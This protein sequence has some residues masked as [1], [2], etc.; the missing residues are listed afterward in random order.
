MFPVY[1]S[2]QVK[3]EIKNITSPSGGLIVYDNIN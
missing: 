3:H 1:L 2:K